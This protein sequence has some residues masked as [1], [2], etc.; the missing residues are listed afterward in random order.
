MYDFYPDSPAL[1][2]EGREGGQL[3]GIDSLQR[4]PPRPSPASGE[5]KE[6]SAVISRCVSVQR[7]R[8]P[9]GDFYM[10]LRSPARWP[11]WA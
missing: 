6:K 1:A 3:H 9:C 2:G 5:G 11:C 8:T 10:A 7:G 4:P